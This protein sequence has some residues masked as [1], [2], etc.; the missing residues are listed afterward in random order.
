[1]EGGGSPRSPWCPH[2]WV[3]PWIDQGQKLITEA[4]IDGKKVVIEV[5]NPAYAAWIEK[6]QQVLF[7]LLGTLSREV[8]V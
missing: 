3:P 6:D 2:V 8:L 7:Y 1:V 5:D 4:E